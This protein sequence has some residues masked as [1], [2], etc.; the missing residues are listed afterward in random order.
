MQIDALEQLK[1]IILEYSSKILDNNSDPN[2]V[3]RC[4]FFILYKYINLEGSILSK[5]IFA[6]FKD[7]SLNLHHL[8]EDI[9]TIFLR[10][11]ASE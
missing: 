11:I 9:F 5:D 4:K 8:D 2:E 3:T 10:L 1:P 7:I 6:I